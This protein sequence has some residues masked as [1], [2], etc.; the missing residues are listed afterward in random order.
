MSI[1]GF[2]KTDFLFRV[3]G[4]RILPMPLTL[5][6]RVTRGLLLSLLFARLLSIAVLD[7]IRIRVE[8]FTLFHAS[9]MS[10]HAF[11]FTFHILMLFWGRRVWRFLE[12]SARLASGFRESSRRLQRVARRNVRLFWCYLGLQVLAQTCPRN[13][14]WHCS[15]KGEHL[16]FFHVPASLTEALLSHVAFVY[17]A[18]VSGCWPALALCL[19]DYA[20]TIKRTVVGHKL[21]KLASLLLSCR[22]DLSQQLELELLQTIKDTQDAFDETFGPL[23]FLILAFNFCQTFGYLVFI[24]VQEISL[25]AKVE[26]IGLSLT[27]LIIPGLLLA[28]ICRQR[29]LPRLWDQAT[30]LLERSN[31]S[32]HDYRLLQL[33]ER[34]ESRCES[35][36]LFEMRSSS[37]LSYSGCITTFAAVFIQL[38]PAKL[39]SH[40]V[41]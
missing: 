5:M 19:Y 4:H 29:D 31:L 10:I 3:C 27:Y 17:E 8:G 23:A 41:E 22:D 14:Y 36:F 1:P 6:S 26:P 37:L 33:L 9:D 38:I 24:L 16:L 25:A 39:A 12:T 32:L 35:C 20:R 18:F 30:R 2:G 7:G 21:R 13:R 15:W 34:E 28:S 11:N 40:V